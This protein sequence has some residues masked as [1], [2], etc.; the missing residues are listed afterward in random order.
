[1]IS[2]ISNTNYPLD[3]SENV[4]NSSENGD[5]EEHVTTNGEL[6]E[7]ADGMEQGG[8]SM[9]DRLDSV[10]LSGRLKMTSLTQLA[11]IFSLTVNLPRDPQKIE[12][13]V[14]RNTGW[15]LICS[16]KAIGLHP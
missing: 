6:Q 13:M 15:R 8:E 12:I 3:I 16:D 9:C 14:N 11:A 5:A 7:A 2:I 10:K 4:L 1:M